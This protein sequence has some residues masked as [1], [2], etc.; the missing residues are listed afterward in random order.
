MNEAYIVNGVRSAIG[1]F[2]GTLSAVRT[3]DLASFVLKELIKKNP[4][5]NWEQVVMLLWAVQTKLVKTIATL[6]VWQ[7]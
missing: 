6:L 3:D 1:N 7:A 4:N 5:V 2:G